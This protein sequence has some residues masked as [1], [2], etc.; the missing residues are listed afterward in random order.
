MFKVCQ[1]IYVFSKMHLERKKSGNHC[2]R[3]N[4]KIISVH[5]QKFVRCIISIFQVSLSRLRKNSSAS[6]HFEDF[7]LS[8]FNNEDAAVS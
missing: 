4:V 5:F 2:L 7:A 1:I 8:L 6:Q 3:R